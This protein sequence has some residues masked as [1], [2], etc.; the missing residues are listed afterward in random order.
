MKLV[1]INCVYGNGSTGKLVAAIHNFVKGNGDE[2]YVIYGLGERV[3]EKNIIRTTPKLVRKLQS[4]RSRITGFPYGGCIWG[5]FTAL[6]ALERIKPDV[7]H[8]HCC[9]AYMINIYRVLN[10]LKQKHIPTIITHHAEFMYTGGCTH[11][12]DCEKWLT[13]CSKCERISKEHPISY[14]F[15]RTKQEWNLWKNTYTGFEGLIHCTVSDWVRERANKS[16]FFAHHDVITVLNGLDDGIF[17]Y[18]NQGYCRDLGL[19]KNKKIVIHVTPDFGSSIK[20]GHHVI[21]MAKRFQDV[22]F[23]IV[24]GGARQATYPGNCVFVGAVSE[25]TKLAQL[26]SIADVCLITSVRETFSMVCAESLCCGTPV[27]GFKAGGPEAIALTDFSEFVE[28][29]DQ[30]NLETVLKKWLKRDIDKR[31]LSDI[32][33]MTYGQETMCKNYYAIYDRIIRHGMIHP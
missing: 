24:G 1:Q 18:T 33:R 28:Q 25:Q 14:F 19:D 22:L 30:D 31:E 7:V 2:S 8:L 15:D 26:Y 9:N 6:R 21:E 13:G 12:I 3:N 5:T 11:S 27:I 17:Q 29:G 10:Y 4:L 16:P 20:G 32:A 23:L